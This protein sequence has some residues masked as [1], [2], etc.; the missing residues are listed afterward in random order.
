M[1]G[2]GRGAFSDPV[3]IPD[4]LEWPSRQST[5]GRKRRGAARRT[6]SNFDAILVLVGRGC[7]GQWRVTGG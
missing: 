6:G 2:K 5:S 4:A 3:G 7:L 1:E